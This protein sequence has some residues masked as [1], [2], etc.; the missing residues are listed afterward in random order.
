[1]NGMLTNSAAVQ[2]ADC[3]RGSV[4]AGP[5]PISIENAEYFGVATFVMERKCGSYVAV[6]E[7]KRGVPA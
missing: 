1:M 5:E 2:H 6:P 7:I 3:W 4:M